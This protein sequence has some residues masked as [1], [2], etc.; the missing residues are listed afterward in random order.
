MK[1]SAKKH[2]FSEPFLLDIHKNNTSTKKQYINRDLCVFKHP[3]HTALKGPK[4]NGTGFDLTSHVRTC[5]G[6]VFITDH[7][8]SKIWST[9]YWIHI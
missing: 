3:L 9:R 1:L 4:G 6:H 7:V 5:G 2:L 8:K